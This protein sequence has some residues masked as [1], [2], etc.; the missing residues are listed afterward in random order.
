M[1]AIALIYG[2]SG[3]FGDALRHHVEVHHVMARRCL[4]ALAAIGGI[5]RGVLEFRNRPL[6]CGMTTRALRPHQ[7]GVHSLALSLGRVATRAVQKGFLGGDFGVILR[8]RPDASPLAQ[9][10]HQLRGKWLAWV[11]L[12]ARL[13]FAQADARQG[14]MIHLRGPRAALMLGMAGRATA[15]VGMKGGRLHGEQRLVVGVTADAAV[16]FHTF[17]RRVAS[18]TIVFQ[19]GVGARKWPRTNR[20]R[21]RHI[22][23]RLWPGPK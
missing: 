21:N 10:L 8:R 16:G 20:Q 1:A 22:F 9:P 13:Q 12:T 18:G 6:R 2:R 19:K 11:A 5:G 15:D 3:L 14:H 7:L 17:T 23:R 4:V